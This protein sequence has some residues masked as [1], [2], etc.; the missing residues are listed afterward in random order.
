MSFGRANQQWS[1]F[2]KAWYLLNADRQ[3]PGKVADVAAKYLMGMHKPIYHPTSRVGDHV[4]IINAKE[5]AYSGNKWEEKT[6]HSHTGR[7][8]GRLMM[9]AFEVHELDPTWIVKRYVY[10]RLPKG[11]SGGMYKRNLFQ[12]VHVFADENIPEEIKENISFV[13]PQPRRVFKGITDYTQEEIDNFPKL[14]IP[15][16]DFLKR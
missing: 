6:F 1:T 11:S 4:V 12:K 2:S 8:K 13:I 15:S 10:R 7:K 3:P 14:W 16:P 9:R 5:I